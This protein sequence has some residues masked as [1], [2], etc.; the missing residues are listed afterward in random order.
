M[1]ES[2]QNSLPGG[3]AAGLALRG[4]DRRELWRAQPAPR[5]GSSRPCE[6]RDPYAVSSILWVMR[7]DLLN[8]R[9]VTITAWGYGSLRAQGRRKRIRISNIACP[10]TQ[11]RDLAAQFA[12]AL[13]LISLPSDQRAQGKPGAR[14]TR[15]PVCNCY[16]VKR[17]RA[18]RFSGGNPAFPAQWFT[19]YFAL[20][21]VTGL[22]CHRHPRSLART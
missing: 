7:K 18:N 4:G 17:T 21:P 1:A 6:R 12:R 13:L 19:A 15:G 9:V 20:A 22:S 14:C 10:Q 8:R 5:Y 16:W 2:K 11:L 3:Y